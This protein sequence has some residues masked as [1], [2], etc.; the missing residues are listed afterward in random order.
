MKPKGRDTRNNN[1]VNETSS[2]NTDYVTFGPRTAGG[3]CGFDRVLDVTLHHSLYL[4]YGI[5]LTSPARILLLLLLLL[6]QEESCF[7]SPQ[8]GN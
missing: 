1:K 6:P 8:Y 2:S 7:N 3:G 4:G 5:K